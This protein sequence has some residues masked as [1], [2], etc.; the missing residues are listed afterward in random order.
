MPIDRELSSRIVTEAQRIIALTAQI[1]TALD[2]ADQLSG[3]R[4][5]A[6]IELGRLTGMGD[7]GDVDRAVR[8]DR[9]IADTMLVLVARAGPRGISR[10]RLLDEAAMRFAEDVSEAEMDQ[11]LEKLVTSEEIYALGQGY[12]LGAGQSASRRLGG[13]SARQA[14]GRTHKDM[15]LEVLRN[16]PEPLGVADIIHAIRDRFGAEV[17]RTSVSPLLSKLDIRGGIVVHIDDK[18]TVP[19]A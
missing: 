1:D 2:L 5:D 9:T 4:R 10:E 18:W 19:K 7:I 12:A 16:S 11:A 3:S 13:Y 8:M 17:S 6:L 15:I 14:H